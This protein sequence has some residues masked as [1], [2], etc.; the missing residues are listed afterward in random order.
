MGCDM[1]AFFET[2]RDG[3]WELTFPRRPSEWWY[4]ELIFDKVGDGSA[5]TIF[6]P[7]TDEEIAEYHRRNLHVSEPAEGVLADKVKN[8]LLSLPMEEVI[9][10]YGGEPSFYWSY[11]PPEISKDWGPDIER[12]DY[13]FFLTI[14]R[15]SVEY[16]FANNS[17][18][19]EELNVWSARGVPDDVCAEIQKEIADYGVDGH[20]H[21][22]LMVSEILAEERCKGCRQTVDPTPSK[23]F[24]THEPPT[25]YAQYDWLKTH[26]SDPENTRMVFFFDN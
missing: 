24:V 17:G 11:Y 1:H 21:S 9:E 3:K 7:P 10:K 15:E 18:H 6:G 4:E 26:I 25:A 13:D 2:R 16:R 12:R 20:S 19:V 23:P 14:C 5:I 8:H 22:W